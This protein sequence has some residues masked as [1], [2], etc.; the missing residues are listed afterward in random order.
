M[1]DCNLKK[2]AKTEVCKRA[3][4]EANFVMVLPKADNSGRKINLEE[5]KKYIKR[6]NDNFGG[7]TTKPVTLGCWIDEKRGDKI[8][9]EEG[10]AVEAFRDF[11]AK[12]EKGKCKLCDFDAIQRK[13]KLQD[14]FKIMKK[15]AKDVALEYGQASVPIIFDNIHEVTL[16]EGKRKESISRL[17]TGKKMPENLFERY[18]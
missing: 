3:V 17:K 1:V 16:T 7:S 8:Q 6:V 14:D 12:D 2:Y 4:G 15:I 10:F 9:C 5:H 18:I 13:N 11:D